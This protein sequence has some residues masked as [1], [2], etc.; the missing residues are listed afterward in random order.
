MYIFIATCLYI[1]TTNNRAYLGLYVDG[2]SLH[3]DRGSSLYQK[4]NNIYI[5]I[6]ATATGKKQSILTMYESSFSWH[7]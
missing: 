3:V 4:G 7:K 1:Q 2:G 5:T 6:S